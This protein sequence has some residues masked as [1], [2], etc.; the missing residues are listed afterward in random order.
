MVFD[1]A[2]VAS[3]SAKIRQMRFFLRLCHFF[4]EINRI[5]A[6]DYGKELF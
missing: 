4:A 2:K 3:A 1:F 5:F 6:T